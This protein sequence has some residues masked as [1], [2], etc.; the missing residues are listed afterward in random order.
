MHGAQSDVQPGVQTG[1]A[2]RIGP[3]RR[4][5]KLLPKWAMSNATA[6]AALTGAGVVAFFTTWFLLSPM[7]ERV[8]RGVL[9]AMIV[10][11]VVIAAGFA[12]LIGA[13]LWHVWSDRRN[14]LAGSATQ[15]KLVWLFSVIAVVPAIVAFLFAF[16]ILRSSLNDVF[17]ARID[18]Y[19]NTARDLANGLI[20]FKRAELELMLK[21]I[22]YDV[23]RSEEAG[24]GLEGTPIS[25][26]EYLYTQAEIRGLDAL[27]VIDGA[28]KLLVRAEIRPG[29]YRLPSKATMDGLK[30]MG[31]GTGSFGVND[32]KTFDRFRIVLKIPDYQSGY[33]IAYQS[34]DEATT[35]RLIAV[36]LQKSDWEEAQVSRA[37]TERIFLAGYVILAF[38]I[39][40]GAIWSALWAAARLVQPIGRLVNMAGRVSS[41]DLGA[42]VEVL[43]DDG[44]LGVLARS[45][46]HMTAQLQTQRDDLI[47]TNKQFD[48]R[49]RF[50]ETVLS[51]VSAGVIGVAPSGRITIANRLAADIVELNE[52]SITGL[53]ILEVFPEAAELF[54]AAQ[55]PP[56]EEVGAQINIHH[57]GQERALSVRIV[58]DEVEGERGFVV[59]FDDITQLISA[60]RSAAWGDIARRI[61][62]E[63]KNPLTP[64][65][66]SAER[67]RRKYLG[68][69][70][71][72]PEIFEKCTDTIIKHVGDIGRM[73]DEFSSFA[74][75]PKP[76]M[77][78]EDLNEIVRTAAFS[79]RVSFPDIDFDVDA[80]T[81]DAR[82]LCDGRLIAQAIGNI[83]KNAAES[84]GASIAADQAAGV[85]PRKGK[86][87]ISVTTSEGFV[88]VG[89]S[90][91]GVGLPKTERHRLTEPYMTTRAKGTG[92]GLAI[93]KKVAE[94][95][96]G[97]V[98]FED[99][100]ALGPTGA[101]VTLALPQ[102]AAREE[103]IAIAAAE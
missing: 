61:A 3:L 84:I 78:N 55:K 1:A 26:R 6:A 24:A 75:M 99:T 31:A 97:F 38:I 102:A 100:T 73:V 18:T 67:L 23:R 39:L 35:R 80:A 9:Q 51:G 74:R 4:A 33:L 58:S 36:S 30:E 48:R 94:E 5:R 16:T 72:Q 52:N 65:Q 57:D 25:F 11:N 34:M 40:F 29:V 81:G 21:Q 45:M 70:R 62:H 17:G 88:R 13:R 77:A 59:T 90:D 83:L 41:G 53:N 27:Y 37:R 22:A 79:Q 42:R 69:I 12:I 95:H 50:T 92:L 66:L 54:E 56:F 71:N 76:V 10:G 49:R 103:T 63:I 64:I 44:E 47:E 82:A 91:N 86:I 68:E 20:E 28:G 96:A 43:R 87:A 85:A 14:Q 19:H 7:V 8:D 2:A 89:V 60:Q 32:D 15:I 93:V 98:S 46:N 101:L